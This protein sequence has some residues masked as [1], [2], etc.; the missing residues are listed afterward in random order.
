VAIAAR[1]H[2]GL[3]A[4]QR[5]SGIRADGER[6]S[7]EDQRALADGLEALPA[8]PGVTSE[9]RPVQVGDTFWPWHSSLILDFAFPASRAME[10]MWSPSIATGWP[11]MPASST[12]LDGLSLAEFRASAWW[13]RPQGKPIKVV[14]HRRGMIHRG[15]IVVDMFDEPVTAGCAPDAPAAAVRRL[16]CNGRQRPRATR[17][18]GPSVRRLS[19][20]DDPRTLFGLEAP[21]RLGL[22]SVLFTSGQSPFL[23]RRPRWW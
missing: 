8:E 20:K 13:P 12:S 18:P 11:A 1:K 9:L 22:A 19:S 16:G 10:S 17:R 5:K 2:S 15:N 14:Y 3:C 21:V 4:T 23:N 6:L 7:P